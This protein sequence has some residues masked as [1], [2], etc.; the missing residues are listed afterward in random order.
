[1][2]A[3]SITFKRGLGFCKAPRKNF[4]T[5]AMLIKVKLTV[6]NEPWIEL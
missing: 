2:V 3:I 5:V 1:M 4:V 6:L